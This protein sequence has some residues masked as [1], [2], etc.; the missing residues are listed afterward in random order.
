[1]ADGRNE[2]NSAS[3]YAAYC[4]SQE[5]PACHNDGIMVIEM[6]KNDT[7]TFRQFKH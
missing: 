7:A 4:R 5:D 1:M 3:K 6:M 2:V